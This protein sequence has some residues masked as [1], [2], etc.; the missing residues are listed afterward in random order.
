MDLPDHDSLPKQPLPE[1]LAHIVL[2]TAGS[3]IGIGPAMTAL[4]S[5][6]LQRR[7]DEWL[8]SL[9]NRLS[10]L[11]SRFE[12]LQNDEQFIT[13]TLHA[14]TIAL[15]THQSLKL[16]ALRNAVLNVA[17]GQ[18]PDAVK[19]QMFLH[20]VDVFSG[21]HIRILKV[22]QNPQYEASHGIPGSL[23]QVLEALLPDLAGQSDLYNQLWRDLNIRGL[24]NTES[25]QTMMT[26][27]G[28]TAK[29][30]TSMGDEF[31]RFISKP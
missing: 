8:V 31:L 14:S 10:G 28:L 23:T 27:S 4:L 1:R 9:A 6:P 7:R 26:G 11:E 18:A 2:E 25:L 30:T 24:V 15:R 5:V 13:A 16:E 20:W 21:T 29:R 12:D 22:F 17:V 3:A 19:Q